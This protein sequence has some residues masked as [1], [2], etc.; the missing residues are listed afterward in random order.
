MGKKKAV[1]RKS[2]QPAVPAP[3][4]PALTREPRGVAFTL[5]ALW[6]T[7]GALTFW[8]FGYTAM[9]GS[10]LWWHLAAGRWI[11]EQK[12]L[13]LTDPWSF[14]RGGQPWLHHEW[15]SD[16]VYYAWVRLLGIPALVF[17]K[18]AVM[19]AAYG[20]LMR[21]L[22]R[23][24]RD[25]LASYLAAV[26]ALAIGSPF[27]DIRPH[28]YSLLGF[29][30]V[31]NL[32]LGRAAPSRW[33]PLVFLVWVNLH[34]GFLFGLIALGLVLL[35]SAAVERFQPGLHTAGSG[36]LALSPSG[37]YL[38]L[39]A[40]ACVL[41]CLLNPNGLEAFTY[42]LKYAFD[43]TSPFL[44][45]GEWRP[46][47][48]EGGIRSPLYGPAIAA[49]ALSTLIVVVSGVRR[50]ERL[51]C[52]A[53]LALG[54]LTLAMSLRSRRF[55]PIFGMAESLIVALALRR[56]TTPLLGLRDS[57]WWR[58]AP[59]LAALACGAVW[60]FPYPKSAAAFH[61]LTAEDTFPVE[62]CNF[63]EANQLSGR[64]FAYY[65]WG[66]YVHL[67]TMG[68]L[69]VYI[70]GRAD[71]VFDSGTYT[72]YLQVLNLRDGWI[73]IIESSGAPYVL[74][75]KSAQPLAL[76]RTGHWRLLYEDIVSVLLIRA[77]WP[78]PRPLRET[79][80]SPW[81]R[82]TQADEAVRAGRLP[83]AE[84]HLKQALKVMPHLSAACHSLARVQALQG[85]TQ[86]AVKTE[87]RCQ[88]IFPSSLQLSTLRSLLRRGQQKPPSSSHN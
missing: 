29:A 34:G 2:R 50:D 26:A 87:D 31:L 37:K 8:S 56:F 6:Y 33:L 46:P 49:F 54:G 25:P 22:H 40:A 78:P 9:R 35:S 21:A 65:N 77:N 85:R 84:E 69:Q 4:R 27:L 48:Q 43:T 17:W 38:A 68:R 61:H 86:E 41:V 53:G 55:I 82:L 13:P 30:V 15:L 72:R 16:V 36:P 74:W 67:R 75:P 80:D 73:D 58:V 51:L 59:P 19:V 23:L 28:L 11:W 79:P 10:D 88:A 57:R 62:T 45:L 5:G 83:Q 12:S 44:Q 64:V 81:R 66:G 42:P 47:F 32:T 63:I 70:D 18:W 14:T 1:A 3:A 71:T 52:V 39:L 24:T 60:L 7:A 76:L 20:L